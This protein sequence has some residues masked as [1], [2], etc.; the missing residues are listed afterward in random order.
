MIGRE[1]LESL[2]PAWSNLPDTEPIRVNSHS[3]HSLPV[4]AAKWMRIG[5]PGSEFHTTHKVTIEEAD[6]GLVL[7]ADF[8]LKHKLQLLWE[9]AEDPAS[10]PEWYLESKTSGDRVK[11]RAESEAEQTPIGWNIDTLH[12]AP[13][14]ERAVRVEG[15]GSL[16]EG[17]TLLKGGPPSLQKGEAVVINVLDTWGKIQRVGR[18]WRGEAVVKNMTHSD[19][20]LH[21]RDLAV[22]KAGDFE[23]AEV[24]TCA[25]LKA[26]FDDGHP[27]MRKEVTVGQNDWIGRKEATARLHEVRVATLGSGGGLDQ[28]QGP[29][30]CRGTG[31]P[32]GHDLASDGAS[33]TQAIGGDHVQ[34]VPESGHEPPAGVLNAGGVQ[35]DEDEE[36]EDDRG[37]DVGA[38][39]HATVQ[40]CLPW[41][42]IDPQYHSQVRELLVDKY[43]EIVS[44]SFWDIGDTSKTLGKVNIPYK[45]DHPPYPKV[46]PLPEKKRK[47][48]KD[49]LNQMVEAGLARGPI[50]SNQGAPV[51]LIERKD[52]NKP[53]RMVVALTRENE[54]LADPPTVVLPS[55]D[56]ILAKM[57]GGV[58]LMSSLDLRQGFFHLRVAEE[59]LHKSTIATPFGNY[60]ICCV[61]MGWAMGPVMFDNHIRRTLY[62]DPAT[63]KACDALDP[64][65][66]LFLD[67]ITVIGYYLGSHAKSVEKHFQVLDQ[68]FYR[69]RHHG[70]KMNCEKMEIAK[71]ECKILGWIIRDGKLHCDPKRVEGIIKA[72]FPSSRKGMMA[73]VALV[74]T[75]RRV[76]PAAAASELAS[77]YELTS[78]K[79]EYAPTEKHRT[80][81]EACKEYLTSAP[82]FVTLPAREKVKVLFSDASKNIYGGVLCQVTFDAP[83]VEETTQPEPSSQAFSRFDNLGKYLKDAGLE[84]R[85]LRSVGRGEQYAA[86]SALL[87]QIELHELSNYPKAV[88]EMVHAL[89]LQQT[90]LA[91]SHNDLPPYMARALD[92]KGAEQMIRLLAIYTGRDVVLISAGD[93]HGSVETFRGSQVSD[94]IPPFFI[95]RHFDSCHGRPAWFSL[96]VVNLRPY[97]VFSSKDRYVNNWRQYGQKQLFENV[98][99]KLSRKTGEK[100]SLEVISYMS[101]VIDE[102]Q[103]KRPIYE[104]EALGLL[105]NLHSTRD[106]H[107]GSPAL[108][109]IIDSTTA[110]FLFNK[111]VG[112]TVHKVHR[113]SV[114]LR[115][116]YPNILLY[117]VPSEANIS[118]YLSRN[119]EIADKT[120]R[121]VKELYATIS[122][123]SQLEG[124][125]LD[126]QEAAEEVARLVEKESKTKAAKVQ[127]VS[128]RRQ[129]GG[130]GI[131]YR[132]NL[133]VLNETL[134]PLK[135][136]QDAVS[137]EQVRRRQK[138]E[139]PD[140]WEKAEGGQDKTYLFTLGILREET[141]F[142]WVTVV[143]PSLEGKIL[144]LEHLQS[145][146]FLGRDGLFQQ[147]RLRY[148]M[149]RLYAKT[150]TFVKGCINCTLTKGRHTRKEARGA[151][152]IPELP[153]QVVYCDLI[154]GMPKNSQ[155]YTDILTVVC[156]LS[157]MI[158]AY[159]LRSTASAP[160]LEKFKEFLM[161]TNFRTKKIYSDNG[162]TFREAK[163]LT[164]MA[165]VGIEVPTTTVFN[166][167]ARGQI[168]VFNFLI[169]KVLKSLLATKATYDWAD[170]IWLTCVCMNNSVHQTTHAKPS[171][172][173]FGVTDVSPLISLPHLTVATKNPLLANSSLKKQ[174]VD[175]KEQ[176]EKTAADIHQRLTE[177]RKKQTDRVNA[178]R[179]EHKLTEG[180]VVFIKDNRLPPTGVN[181]KLRPALQKSPFL[182]TAVK[183]N[184]IELVRVT[185]RFQTRVA[186]A[187]VVPFHSSDDPIFADIPA[188]VMAEIGTPLSADNIKNLAKV[189]D[190]P[191]LLSENIFLKKEKQEA[192]RQNDK[193]EGEGDDASGDEND[194]DDAPEDGADQSVTFHTEDP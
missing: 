110:F 68:V 49:W 65:V 21:P 108:L 102:T 62:T 124:K 42:K 64:F 114:T 69:L 67:D 40:D 171:E 75:L 11:L 173:I 44:R 170:L 55:T 130:I 7:G 136:L 10:R 132:R 125:F 121:D 183:S 91:G 151:G 66:V 157:K 31:E 107:V 105:H 50:N 85:I 134:I 106:M 133:D 14:E 139:L 184:W 97:S 33:T 112:E 24:Y 146:H 83:I 81:F 126:T 147:M 175:L 41:D 120:V 103:Q 178:T 153:L 22:E 51:F 15:E 60:E 113:W 47:V 144:A 168:E 89:E 123:R 181:W 118:D 169:E 16:P 145:G 38:R 174:V 143:P 177:K 18:N 93:K 28:S 63:G 8:I 131:D 190:L 99:Q 119:F 87:S 140:L 162:T 135:I 34:L 46:F 20:F 13:Q 159:P 2:V 161:C 77:L 70:W 48:L 30:S 84:A 32:E 167:Q 155:K 193:T 80:A 163:F 116:R 76:M 1:Y 191:L 176:L 6:V 115:Q 189:D 187:D 160:V 194:D 185:D 56:K 78:T 138:E 182:V 166:S 122:P 36:E 109:V 104:K 19:V 129:P 117:S 186:P 43:P 23:R 152:P 3:N 154:S 12:L 5:F 17:N 9:E 54:C 98:K 88:T 172:V 150:R 141:E 74:G 79:V 71:T 72:D 59:D 27:I 149:P 188:E 156:P 100:P 82:L 92:A 148:T 26:E 37:P 96:Y 179:K 101:K 35:A 25:Q 73:F 29:P 39:R 94:E 142:G 164:F 158:Y 192:K 4:V 45:T 127:A 111:S 165:S 86:I 53:P 61:L 128:T 57:G 52:P 137:A 58:Y 180:Q 90:Q 95:G